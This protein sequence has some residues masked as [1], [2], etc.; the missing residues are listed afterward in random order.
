MDILEA[1][2]EVVKAGIRLVESGLIARTWG[3]VSCRV[4]DE[5]FVITPSGRS[6]E[7][8]T[9]DDIV[10]VRI[11]DCAYT[12]EIKPSSEKGV[13][14]EAYKHRSDVN[15]VIHTHQ[16]NAS[17]ISFLGYDI[18][19]VPKESRDIIGSDIPV[20]SYGLPGTGKLRKG[21]T[22]AI[23][24]SESKAVIMAH[25]GALCMGKD[26]DEAFAV[27]GELE[28]VCGQFLLDRLEAVSGKIA[29]NVTAVAEHVAEVSEGAKQQAQLFDPYTSERDGSTMIMSPV[30]GGDS[31]RIDLESGAEVGACDEYPASAELHR[32][33]YNTRE[34]INCV[35]HSKKPE[36]VAASRMGIKFRPLLDDFAQLVGVTLKTGEYNPSNT[37]KSA[38][39]VVKKLKGRN[40]VLVKDNGAICAAGNKYDAEAVEMVL[41][42][43]IRTDAA[44]RLIGDAKYINPVE[45]LLMRIIYK[46]KYSKKN[47]TNK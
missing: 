8:L 31:V 35:L 15:F 12:S 4:D 1:K 23:E 42:K 39:K 16:K 25:H 2:E 11:E 6:Y 46:T 44:A 9:V 17:A 22:A 36:L 24:R 5:Y 33:V 13:H 19:M 14:A 7:S 21:V 45:A 41:E 32:A 3:N 47:E 10:L 34:D 20:A 30:E 28:K 38:K 18:N 29:D 40:A 27:A 37:V 26:Y 43:E